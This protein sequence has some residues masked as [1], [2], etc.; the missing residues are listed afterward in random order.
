MRRRSALAVFIHSL[1]QPHESNRPEKEVV[2]LCS[3]LLL[4][5]DRS[6]RADLAPQRSFT[7]ALSAR[8]WLCCFHLSPA[9]SPFRLAEMSQSRSPGGLLAGIAPC[10][11]QAL[12][13][14]G[15][16]APAA[17]CTSQH[18]VT[19]IWRI[20]ATGRDLH[21]AP[22]PLARNSTATEQASPCQCSTRSSFCGCLSVL[23]ARKYNRTKYCLYD[24][25]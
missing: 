14:V 8:D 2:L 10:V 20:N 5:E 13:S 9:S 19:A 3:F 16:A 22:K 17:S 24:Y 12:Q 25:K 18:F 21:A 4:A 15:P 11:V 7:A 6:K 23:A 1:R